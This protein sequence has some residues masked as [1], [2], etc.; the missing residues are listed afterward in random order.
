MISAAKRK[1]LEEAGY[2]V[3]K[4]GK[5][6]QTK[7]GGTVAGI[8][9]NGNLFGSANSKAFKILKGEDKAKSDTKGREKPKE[10]KTTTSVSKSSS[11]SAPSESKRPKERQKGRGEPNYGEP[12]ASSSGPSTRQSN[13]PSKTNDKEETTLLRSSDKRPSNNILDRVQDRRTRAKET[14]SRERAEERATEKRQES[15]PS[16]KDFMNDKRRADPDRFREDPKGFTDKMREMYKQKFGF[17]K[18]GMVRKGNTNYKDKGM[19][20][21]SASPRGYK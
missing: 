13:K 2:K 20:Y 16:F 19:F 17:N 1:Q 9:E 10:R 3:N 11:S 6:V 18:G 5:T 4:S 8:N 15:A 21:K 12:K 14:L 7:S